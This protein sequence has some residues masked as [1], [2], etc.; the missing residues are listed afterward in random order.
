MFLGF[1]SQCGDTG[2]ALIHVL[3]GVFFRVRGC[4]LVG[5][6]SHVL[7][8]LAHGRMG[9]RVSMRMGMRM[10]SGVEEAVTGV[11]GLQALG[12]THEAGDAVDRCSA[13]ERRGQP[14]VQGE[15]VAHG[16]HAG[17]NRC[18][19]VEGQHGGVVEL[20][21]AGVHLFLTTPFSSAVLEPDLGTNTEC[22]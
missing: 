17:V 3:H 8:P 12:W 6:R 5:R 1:H 20:H 13:G 14:G 7:H 11:G 18:G 15:G 22:D 10:R 19:P 21:G 9:V 2:T 4:T 16:S